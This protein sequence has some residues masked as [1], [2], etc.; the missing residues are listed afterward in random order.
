MGVGLVGDG[1][2][3]GRLI[4]EFGEDGEDAEGYDEEMVDL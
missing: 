2:A 4:G 3:A 1:K